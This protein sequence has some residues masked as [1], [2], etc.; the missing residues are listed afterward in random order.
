M[1]LNQTLHYRL[2]IVSRTTAAIIGGYSVAASA[3]ALLAVLLP[4]TRADAVI[5]ATLLSFIVYTCAVLWVFAARNTWQ[6]WIGIVVPTAG[7]M[8]GVWLCRGTI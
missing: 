3:T 8:L 1:K 7:M 2:A 6:A 4:L 5:T